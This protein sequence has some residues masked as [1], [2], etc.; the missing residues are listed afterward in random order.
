MGA[1][2]EAEM[3]IPRWEDLMVTYNHAVSIPM[4]YLG[5]EKE[6]DRFRGWKAVRAFLVARIKEE[7]R[8]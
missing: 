1:I 2:D 6:I 8:G 5:R 3:L 4:E 7:N